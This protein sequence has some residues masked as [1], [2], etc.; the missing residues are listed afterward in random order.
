MELNGVDG[1]IDGNCVVTVGTFVEVNEGLTEGF[2]VDTVG[3]NDGCTE[4]DAVGNTVG[5]IVEGLNDGLQVL[6]DG[7]EVEGN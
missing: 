3:L 2:I 7:V 6:I 1:A 4:G 5:V